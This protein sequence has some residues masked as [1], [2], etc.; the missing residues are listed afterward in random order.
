MKTEVQEN[1]HKRTVSFPAIYISGDSVA[2]ATGPESGVML[3]QGR[4]NCIPSGEEIIDPTPWADCTLW[5]R[6]TAPVTI[7]F[8][9]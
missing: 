5:E 8:T 3:H 1:A 6:A 4:N 7:T 2:L 9:P